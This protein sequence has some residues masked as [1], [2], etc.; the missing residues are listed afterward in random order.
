[1]DLMASHFLT[2]AIL[3]TVLPIGLLLSI[4]VYW[5]VLLRRRSREGS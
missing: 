4:G 5:M 1:M 3:S 2:G